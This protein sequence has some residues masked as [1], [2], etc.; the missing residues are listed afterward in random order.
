[1]RGRR[2]RALLRARHARGDAAD[3]GL[4]AVLRGRDRRRRSALSS[5]VQSEAS[6][7]SHSTGS[8]HVLFDDAATPQKS[9]AASGAGSEL[10]PR[11]RPR[12]ES[13]ETEEKNGAERARHVREIH[14]D[15]RS[16][17]Y[18]LLL[19]PP[20]PPRESDP[21]IATE[22]VGA[23]ALLGAGFLPWGLV[24]T[25]A[26]ILLGASCVGRRGRRHRR[27]RR[28][29]DRSTAGFA[30]G[31]GVCPCASSW[32]TPSRSAT[33]SARGCSTAPGSAAPSSA[34]PKE[35]APGRAARSAPCPRPDVPAG[36]RGAHRRPDRGGAPRRAPRRTASTRRSRT[37]R[38]RGDAS[39]RRA[40]RRP[41]A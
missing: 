16:T 38:A 23:C 3:A 36:P 7:V 30:F 13:E 15:I 29:R 12:S 27:R 40:G 39:A 10:Q 31:D 35:P 2:G 4:E 11:A 20:L 34:R 21:R 14:T 5:E 25:G 18:F 17:P 19:P 32:R 22:R 41:R 1:M 6:C 8:L 26:C 9:F 37:S 24:T 28:R 33:G